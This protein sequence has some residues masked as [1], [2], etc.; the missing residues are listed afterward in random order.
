VH[1]HV[2]PCSS[3]W[4]FVRPDECGDDAPRSW[5]DRSTYGNRATELAVP[6]G[7]GGLHR[8]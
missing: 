1:G 5:L 2:K 3:L 6:V 7:R 4:R 8:E